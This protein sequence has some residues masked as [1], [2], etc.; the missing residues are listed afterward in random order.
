MGTVPEFALKGALSGLLIVLAACDLRTR[1]IPAWLTQPALVAVAL[2]RALQGDVAAPLLLFAAFTDQWWQLPIVL[3]A[4]VAAPGL[5]G[6]TADPAVTFAWIGILALWRAHVFGGGD[7]K[8]LMILFGLYPTVELV[9][10]I[11]LV[12]I[13]VCGPLLLWQYR[14]PGQFMRP[15][16]PT[17]ER[18]AREGQP[19]A[20]IYS[21]AGLLYLWLGV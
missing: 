6:H 1:L 16:W 10:T 2:G 7:T 18:L 3:F 13:A 14:Q 17:A 20:F 21:L 11:C 9:I 8:L 5:P 19:L 15:A 12:S 4:N